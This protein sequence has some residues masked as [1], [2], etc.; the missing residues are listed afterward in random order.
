MAR[1]LGL[2]VVALAICFIVLEATLRWT[3]A[4]GARTSWSE[5][6]PLIAYRYTPGRA[7][8]HHQ[9]N[10]HPIS[11]TVN[12]FGWRDRERTLEK[13]PGTYRIAVL[14][15]SFVEAFQVEQDSTFLSVAEDRL[16]RTLPVRVEL[17]NLGRSGASQAEEYLVLQQDAMAFDPDMV[18]VVVIPRND[19]ADIDADTADGTL[20]PFYS[21]GPDGSLVLDASFAESREYALRALINPLKQRSVVVSLLAERYNALRA[22]GPGAT[23]GAGADAPLVISGHL[24][25]CT[26]TPDPKYAANYRLSKAILSAMA[27]YCVKRDVRFLLIVG[28]NVA[29]PDE[30][31]GYRR[32]D[33]SFDPDFFDRDLGMLAET[34]GAEYLGLQEPFRRTIAEGGGP[35]HWAHWNYAGHRVVAGEVCRLLGGIL[36]SGDG[37]RT[38]KE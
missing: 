38:G 30:A 12:A 10:D 1:G 5:P 19:I 37:E 15:D 18:A 33:A 3:H 26:D 27:D 16:C 6:D 23:A 34:L 17:L 22:A 28:D 2:S 4:F 35:L 14:G 21:L 36:A 11:G 29:D 25:L 20:R 31:R 24:T 32:L 13:P 9:E 7:Y 8:W